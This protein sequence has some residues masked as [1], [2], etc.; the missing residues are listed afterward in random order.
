MLS[1]LAPV[2]R[3]ALTNYLMQTVIC[4]FIFYGYGFGMFGRFGALTDTLIALAIFLFQILM[5]SL[6]LK[7]FN[8]GPVEWIWRQL[9]YRQ[10]LNLRIKREYIAAESGK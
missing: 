6:W 7:Y 4:V 2:G 3:M 9:T 5:S 10:R 8:Y 1:Y